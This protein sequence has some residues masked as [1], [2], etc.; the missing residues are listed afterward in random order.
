MQAVT[1]AFSAEEVDSVRK[2]AGS[3]QVAWKKVYNPSIRI[4]TIGV[5]LIGGNDT[6]NSSGGINSDWNKYLYTDESAYLT[7]LSYERGL[8]YPIGGMSKALADVQVDNTSGRFTPRYA[9]GSSE[10]YTAV[11]LPLRPF[12]VNAGFNYEGTDHLI[13]QFVGLTSNP[14]HL[15][16]RNKTVE[17]KGEDFIRYLQTQYVDD[18]SMFT[19]QRT[20]QVLS[21]MMSQLGFSTAQ[22]DFDYGINVINFGQ[23]EKGDTFG[24]HADQMVKAENGYLYQDEAGIIRFDNRQKWTQSPYNAVQRVITTAQVIEAESPDFDDIINVVEIKSKPRAKQPQ[25]LVWTLPSYIELAPNATTEYF[26]NFDDP[27]LAVTTPTAYLANSAA[28]GT[29]TDLTASV[30]ITTFTTFASAAKIRFTNTSSQIAY[31]TSLNIFGRP[32]KVKSEI[33]YREMDSSSHTAYEE[34]AY[35]IEDNP[36]IQDSVWAQ[37]LARMIIRDYGEPGNVQ[38]IKIRAIPE[39]Q[40]G[41]LVSWQGRYWR[42]FD[43]RTIIS[44]DEGFVQYLTLLQRTVY[45]YFRIGISTIGGSDQIAP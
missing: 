12:I 21:T 40:L 25:Q 42:V 29:G 4:F 9:G 37:S 39:L 19:G 7:R 17:F 18:S 11:G 20:D 6:I 22:Y 35:K 24:Y 28:D 33:Y 8:N 15:N 14:P 1:D 30:A 26:V 10:I 44:P 45:S 43:I 23:W 16:Y 41:D 32:A 38:K 27:M 5:S 34:H 13:P 2:V 31:I 36:Y 3:F